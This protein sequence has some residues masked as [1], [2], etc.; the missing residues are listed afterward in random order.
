MRD[1]DEGLTTLVPLMLLLRRAA[2]MLRLQPIE[3]R[4]ATMAFV[5]VA[6]TYMTVPGF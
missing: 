2:S 5:I 1:Q 6:R 3:I 4:R